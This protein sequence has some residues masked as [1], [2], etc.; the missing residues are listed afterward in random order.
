MKNINNKSIL[1]FISLAL[2]TA[3]S[4]LSRESALEKIRSSWKETLE[5]GNHLDNAQLQIQ[6]PDLGL[7]VTLGPA[8]G[9]GEPF[10]AASVGKL[11]TTVLIARLVEEGKLD[12]ETKVLPIL[13]QKKLDRLYDL[14]G[15]DYAAQVTIRQLLEH[16]SGIADYFADSPEGGGKS[17]AELMLEFPDRSWTPDDLLD[18][19]RKN[20]V[21]V[22]SPGEKFHY[23][24]SGFVLLGMVIEK[25]T[26]Q[27]FHQALSEQ[28]FNPLGMDDSFMPGR[29]VSK[30]NKS[31]TPGKTWFQGEE[32]ESFRSLTVDWAGGGVVTTTGN[33]MK[34]DRA[35]FG[36]RLLQS[37]TMEYLAHFDHKF[38]QGMH[39]GR[40]MMEYYFE[41]FFPLLWGYPRWRGHL[42]ILATH[43]LYDPERNIYIVMN[44]GSDEHLEK[45]FRLLIDL[46]GI[47]MRVQK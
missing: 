8:G 10:H 22:G 45:S 3:C 32:V 34:F 18:F 29:S 36:N 14:N 28:I 4:P 44:M 33:L 6:A 42:G 27:P 41:E 23:S 16:T 25:I 38:D 26:G 24:D 9:P 35:L 30:N 15:K 13:G 20:L 47:L 31:Q 2:L 39:Y 7:D 43:C 12:W 17:V 21:P 46:S 40:G 1:V 11:F 19:H 5:D 37:G